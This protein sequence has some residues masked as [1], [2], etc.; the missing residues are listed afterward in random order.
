MPSSQTSLKDILVIIKHPEKGDA[1]SGRAICDKI[2][3]KVEGTAGPVCIYH[4]A[5][6]M[7]NAD[8]GYAGEF[9]QLDKDLSGRVVEIV[10]AIPGSIPRMMAHT[11]A[12]FSSKKWSIFKERGEAIRYLNLRG[13]SISD[14]D[15]ENAEEVSVKF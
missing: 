12:M 11:V 7:L 14:M 5:T 6:G 15:V 1:D 10:C 9:K 8:S 3:R 13:Y 4:D 2:R